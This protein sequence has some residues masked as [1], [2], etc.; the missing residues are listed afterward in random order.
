M[1]IDVQTDRGTY[2]VLIRR[3]SLSEVG[4]HLFLKRKVLVITDRSV[5]LQ[6]ANAVCAAS[7][8][9][10]RLTVEAGEESKSLSN[11][12]KISSVLLEHGFT[13][14]DCIVAV[15][16]GTVMD[17]AGFVAATFLRGIELYLV[18]TTLLGQVDAPLDGKNAVH[19]DRIKN[20]LGT[21]YLPGRILMDPDVLETLPARQIS[22]GLAEAIK[23]AL[24]FD[25]ELFAWMETENLMD[26]RVIE[27]IIARCVKIKKQV[28]FGADPNSEAQN[29]LNF[30]H[31]IGHGM[32]CTPEFA[33]LSHGECVA[34]G[35]LPVC[36]PALRGRVRRVLASAGLPAPWKCDADAIY[37][38]MLREQPE[39]TKHISTVFCDAV[40]QYRIRKIPFTK[41]YEI[42]KEAYSE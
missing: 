2:D 28:L 8:I 1:K 11:Y 5:P 27:K 35:M 41:I 3:G 40:G 30:G 25:A 31:T 7:E 18:P 22:G 12:G 17:L 39:E 13:R 10:L 20:V 6:Y 16:G 24:L 38:A 42:L 37:K 26:G 32:E 36:A 23:L 14:A 29:A 4:K 21:Y 15:G 19:L 34:F 33:E 9:P